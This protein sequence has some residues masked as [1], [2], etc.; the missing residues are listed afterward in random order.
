MKD[1]EKYNVVK[2]GQESGPFDA[3]EIMDLLRMRQLSTI[4]KVKLEKN[5]VPVSEFIDLFEKGEL[6]HQV[7]QQKP[8]AAGVTKNKSQKKIEA[9]P[10]PKIKPKSLPKPTPPIF[11]MPG[12]A[13]EIHINRSG[14]RFGPYLLKEIKNYLKSGNLRFSDMVWYEGISNW[15]PLSQIPGIAAG[16][17]SLGSVAPP[18]PKP[19]P[20]PTSAPAPPPLQKGEG[21]GG[22]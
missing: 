5:E 11:P 20:K 4:D 10:K 15:M 12:P 21:P 19:P 14:T 3:T 18:P 16:I 1:A 8:S 13:S 6:P 7:A 2:R 17:D 9:K 22:V